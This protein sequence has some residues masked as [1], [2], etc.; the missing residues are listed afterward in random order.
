[1]ADTVGQFVL[2]IE[3]LNAGR[4]GAVISLK[5]EESRRSVYAQVRRSRPLSILEPFDLPRM[6]PNCT[7]R[8]SS[9]VAPQSLLMMNS[10]FVVT[11]ATAFAA[12]LVQEAGDDM[13]DQLRLAWWYSYGAEPTDDEL[14]AA[15]QFLLD[16]TVHFA[17]NPPASDPA[18]K[19]AVPAPDPR[20]EALASV[21]HALLSSNR[22]LYVD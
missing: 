6:E 4:P 10:D 12:R 20:H 2:G 18:A 15:A 11:E 16:Q 8:A 13:L 22:F 9:T 17:G 14:G 1:M 7:Q 21:C 5:G 19:Q 3:N